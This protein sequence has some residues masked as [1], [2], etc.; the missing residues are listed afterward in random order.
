[1]FSQFGPRKKGRKHFVYCA[2][3]HNAIVRYGASENMHYFCNHRCYGK[4]RKGRPLSPEHREHV[5]ANHF[6]T[7]VPIACG[8]CKKLF[9]PE[10]SRR[11]YC[12]KSC[13]T[14]GMWEDRKIQNLMHPQKKIVHQDII[15]Y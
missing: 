2:Y 13:S 6:H 8:Y 11:K 14:K 5:I 9:M 3:C 4:Y 12:Q 15:F 10:N 1:M 7:L